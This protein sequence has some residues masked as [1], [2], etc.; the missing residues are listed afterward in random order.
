M[1]TQALDTRGA[2]LAC[3]VEKADSEVTTVTEAAAK[4]AAEVQEIEEAVAAKSAAVLS[5]KAAFAE[6]QGAVTACTAALKKARNAQLAFGAELEKTREQKENFDKLI[7][8]HLVP[9]TEAST[10]KRHL[11]N[12]LAAID[13]AVKPLRLD[14]A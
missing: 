10:Q 8:E 3:E 13:L 12:H 11:K 7:A 4:C 9:L 5:N 14:H 2:A 6:H 1:L